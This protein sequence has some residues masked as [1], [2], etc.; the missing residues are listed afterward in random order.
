MDNILAIF[1]DTL[2][3]PETYLL[4]IVEREKAL[5]KIRNCPEKIFQ[6]RPMS[7]TVL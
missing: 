6:K 4:Q 5:C 7:A 1:N 3:M 2:K